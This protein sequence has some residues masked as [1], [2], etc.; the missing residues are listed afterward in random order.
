MGGRCSLVCTR[1]GM[2]GRSWSQLAA[3]RSQDRR[4]P[5]PNSFRC[6]LIAIC[7]GSQ[8]II[9]ALRLESQRETSPNLSK[10]R[11]MKDS[12]PVQ[13]RTFILADKSP[14]SITTLQG[15]NFSFTQMH[16]QARLDKRAATNFRLIVK[17]VIRDAYLCI[18]AVTYH[19]IPKQDATIRIYGLLR[20]R[21]NEHA[22]ILPF[23]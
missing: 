18:F 16:L 12:D 15:Y 20:L 17:A 4:L 11:R 3:A 19:I 14:L 8:C 9:R 22:A 21:T 7:Q 5:R 2:A 10:D 23:G 13:W 1:S 6:N